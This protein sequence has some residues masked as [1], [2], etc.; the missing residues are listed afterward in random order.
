VSVNLS[1]S[2]ILL[3][4]SAS[5]IRAALRNALVSAGALV[6]EVDTLEAA[7]DHLSMVR[8]T[9]VLLDLGLPDGDGL[10]L[11]DLI[12][13]DVPVAALAHDMSEHT[14]FR[15]H[16]AGCQSVIIKG[17]RM[18]NLSNTMAQLEA[19]VRR[20][21]WRTDAQP[22]LAAHG[23]THLPPNALIWAQNFGERL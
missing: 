22:A 2:C 13:A 23:A 15:C 9:S 6:L 10:E 14:L 1:N 19:A 21:S 17:R 5:S 7:R 12:G 20:A 16:Q 3:I 8:P 11:M 18:L 4:E